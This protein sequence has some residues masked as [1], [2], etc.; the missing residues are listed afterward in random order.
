MPE[1]P[2]VE[3]IA[4]G[5]RQ[6][7]LGRPIDKVACFSPVIIKGS[8][9][10]QWQSF[11]ATFAGRSITSVTRREKRLILATTDQRALVFQLGMTGKF[12]L[13]QR[14]DDRHKH[15]HLVFS[16][17]GDQELHYVDTRRFGRLWLF[18]CLDPQHPDAAMEAEG[19]GSLGPEALRLTSNR[20]HALLDSQR[21]IKTLLLDQTRLT[22][23]GNIYAD[24]SLFASGIHPARSSRRIG[25]EEATTL[26]RQIKGVLRRAIRA[27]GTTFSDFENAYGDIGRF[28]K[29]LKVYGRQG[30]PCRSCCGPIE[31]IVLAGRGTHICPR[32]QPQDP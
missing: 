10:E 7:I 28:R 17:P 30:E 31:R 14:S 8:R 9:S 5:L 13:K 3:N 29:R 20:F 24:E 11:L 22:G 16:F 23:L 32:C 25:S 26:L 19:M 2:E 18:D 4:M 27:G 6:S 1:L 21:S 15:T 12:L